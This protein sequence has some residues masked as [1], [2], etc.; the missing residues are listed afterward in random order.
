MKK[1]LLTLL[2]FGTISLAFAAPYTT[3]QGGT[4]TSTAYAN[5]LLIGNPTGTAWTVISTS[6][7]GI[8]SGL[9]NAYASSTFVSFSYA[10][11]TFASTTGLVSYYVPYTGATGNVNLGSNGLTFG[12]GSSTNISA[13]TGATFA[14]L[15]VTGASLLTGNASSTKFSAWGASF[16]NIMATGTLLVLGNS[17]TTNLSAYG[18]TFQNGSATGTLDVA[19]KFTGTT[20]STTQLSASTGLFSAAIYDSGALNVIGNASTTLFS[21][22]GATFGSLYATSTLGVS[23]QTTLSTAS[24]TQI[25]AST[26]A[27][28]ANLNVP[29]TSLFTGLATFANASTTNISASTGAWLANLFVNANASTSALSASTFS[30]GNTGINGTLDIV[31]KLTGTTASTTQLSAS[32]GLFAAAAY[33]SGLFNVVGTS[34]LATTTATWLLVGTT[35]PTY[36][37]NVGMGTTPETVKIVSG[38]TSTGLSVF[39]NTNDFYQVAVQNNGQGINAESCYTVNTA[40][41]TNTSIFGAICLNGPQFGTTTAYDVGTRGDFSIFGSSNDFYIVNAST[42]GKMAFLTGG[43]ATSTNTRLSI[44]SGGVANFTGALQASS[45]LAV[46]SGAT[47]YSTLAVLGNASTTN[48]ST[49]GLTFQNGQATGTLDVLGK[50]TGTTASTTQISASTGATVAALNVLGASLHTGVATFGNSSTTAATISGGLFDSVASHGTLGQ[51]LWST[52]TSTIWVSTTTL[53]INGSL[54]GG[55]NGKLGRWTSA[56]ALATGIFLDN[57]T[58]GG[59]NATSSTYTFNLQAN[60][61]TAAL[62]V[63]SSSSALPYLT[64]DA[65]G[66]TGI[67]TSTPGSLFSVNGNSYFAG[68]LYATGT[69]TMLGASTLTTA[70]TTQ[71]TAST[72]ATLAALNVPGTSLFTGL[73]SLSNAST[74]AVTIPT[75]YTGFTV[76]SV[77]FIS[78]SGVL[79][80]NNSNFFWDNTNFRMGIATSAPQFAL[81]V[82][83]GSIVV[84]AY[85]WGTATTTTPMIDWKRANKQTINMSTSAFT[86]DMVNSTSSQGGGVQLMVCN[87][88]TGTPGAITWASSL[89]I[90][91]PSNTIPTA[92]SSNNTCAKYSFSA[93]FGTSSW[94][95]VGAQTQF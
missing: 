58:V 82:A 9:T 61:A 47:L 30:S 36:W 46:T 10:S 25:T 33:V 55:I 23:G 84:G 66:K 22:Y 76:G 38:T 3:F 65:S 53:G 68:N 24:T 72:G 49:Y 70:S 31:G 91:W 57:G 44:T 48:T 93:E 2:T 80:Q 74:S 60:A 86:V 11:S 27:T 94:I 34:T 16:G 56:T 59:I 19:G 73:V 92:A 17:S 32:T 50:F 95:I 78:T 8:I 28:L 64:I 40:S 21:A 45:T 79:A 77:P 26:G 69:L 62:N 5:Q 43:S 7:L 13:S 85:N 15:Q 4:G 63:S 41:S 14:A 81:S 29:G 6:S 87:P 39:G 54:S 90:R 89:Q 52:A 71:V 1:L 12:N 75:L 37:T 20:A 42:T 18:L 67:G 83:T 88:P 51:V 35:T